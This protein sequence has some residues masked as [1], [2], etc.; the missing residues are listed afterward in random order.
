MR[1][2]ILAGDTDG[3]LGDLAIVTA[4]CNEVRRF[5]EHAEIFLVSSKPDRDRKNPRVVPIPRGAAGFLPLLSAARQADVV[6]C[7]GGG[8]FQDDDSLFKMPYWAIRLWIVRRVSGPIIGFCIGAGPLNHP[9]S[10]WFARLALRQLDQITVRDELAKT[11]LQPLTPKPI[12]VAPDPAFSLEAAPSKVAAQV[13]RKNR[14]PTGSRPLVGVS[15]CRL[16]HKTS[17]LPYKYARRLGLQRNA[18]SKQMSLFMQR[19]A[20]SLDHVARESGAH[21]VFLPTYSAAHEDDLDVCRQIA[22]R[23]RIGTSSLVSCQD[24]NTYKALTGKMSVMLCGRMHSAILAAGQCTP[25]VA[26]AYNQ[27][28]AGVFSLLGQQDRCI[29]VLDF[30]G[31][32][33]LVDLGTLLL[34]SIADPDRFRPQPQPL[35]DRFSELVSSLIRPYA[36]AAN[37]PRPRLSHE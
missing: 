31:D 8:L 12:A 17:V 37:K 20:D 10:R 36:Q 34:S 6:L 32:K 19:V 11:S 4:T 29:D 9:I 26:L 18:G 35:I 27:K 25:I 23:L 7:G 3:N 15:V 13:L 30:I 14:V 28:F 24:P 2:L 22:S 1:I 5:V 16:F 33:R 21:V